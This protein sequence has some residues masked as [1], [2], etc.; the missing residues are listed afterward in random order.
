MIH[1]TVTAIAAI[2]LFQILL[3]V[4]G[5]ILLLINNVRTNTK[6]FEMRN[7][8]YG[9]GNARFVMNNSPLKGKVAIVTGSTSGLGTQTAT[10]LYNM[11]ASVIIASRTLSKCNDTIAAI[12]KAHPRAP[13]KIESMQL[14]TSDFDNVRAFAKRFNATHPKLH[15]LVNNAGIHYISSPG[16]PLFN[17]KMKTESKQG[18]D[19]AFA[20]N[21]MV[22][23]YTDL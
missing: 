23:Y 11:G 9:M 15:F 22:T 20:T 7:M 8:T 17:P 14:D 5:F 3:F 10:D 2:I 1:W 4:L 21:Y 6:V 12:K 16:S 18:F 13:G 19:L